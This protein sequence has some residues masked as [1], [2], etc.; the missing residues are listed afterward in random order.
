VN[1]GIEM[2]AN[3]ECEVRYEYRASIEQRGQRWTARIAS[4]KCTAVI[5]PE[6][7]WNTSPESRRVLDHE[8]GHFDL[9]EVAARRAEQHFAG[10]IRD[11]KITA[12]GMDKQ[13]VQRAIDRAIKKEMDAVY[14]SL[15]KAQKTYDEETRH[16]TALVAQRR[17]RQWQRAELEKLIA[18][19]NDATAATQKP[20]AATDN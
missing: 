12:T 16:G 1:L 5:V 9:A 6:K 14:E 7:C 4:F 19:K 17:Y 20:S 8:Q 18:V 2:V 13:S 11:G 10:L 15:D 3:T